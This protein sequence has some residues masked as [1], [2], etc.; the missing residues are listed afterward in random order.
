MPNSILPAGRRLAM[1]FSLLLPAL[2]LGCRDE[3]QGPVEEALTVSA[4]ALTAGGARILGFED[5][6][7]WT[8]TA[9]TKG[10]SSQRI[11]GLYSLSLSN[12]GYVEVRS[13]SLA[14]LGGVADTITIDLTLPTAQP[15]PYWLGTV[16]LK[17]DLPSQGIFAVSLGQREL[18]GQPLGAFR[19]F[20]F[21]LPT[22]VRDKLRATY[23]DLTF[24]VIL[25][26]PAGSGAYLL[27]RLNVGV[28]I[29]GSPGSD[30]NAQSCGPG[31]RCLLQVRSP[32]GLP[33]AL[34]RFVGED[35]ITLADRTV[36][37]DA[38]SK[39]APIATSV[40]AVELGVEAKTG[41][42]Y[43]IGAV[44]LRNNARVDGT[45]RALGQ[46][47]VGSGAT[48]TGTTV[49]T[50]D[51]KPLAVR[52]WVVTI[53]ATFSSGRTVDAD[54][55]AALG[56]PGAYGDVLV[57]SR[58]TLTL[59]S[60][61]YFLKSLAIQSGATVRVDQSGGPLI[62]YVLDS[63][64]YRGSVV[65][66]T[67]AS[68]NLMVGYLGTAP[69]LIEARFGGTF[70]APYATLTLGSTIP[71]QY[72]GAFFAKVLATGPAA[73]VRL[74]PS[75]LDDV[76]DGTLRDCTQSLQLDQSLPEPLRM[77]QAQ[78]DLLRFCLAPG[79]DE[80]ELRMMAIANADRRALALQYVAKAIDAPTH[81]AVTR[82]ITRKVHRM[83]R[84]PALLSKYCDGDDDGDRVPNGDDQCPATPPLTPTTAVGCTDSARPQ[85]APRAVIDLLL[86]RK[87][88]LYN[89]KCDGAAPP[90]VPVPT[91]CGMGIPVPSTVYSLM[92]FHQ[93]TP[94]PEMVPQGCDM[95]YEVQVFSPALRKSYTMAFRLGET[96]SFIPN[97][98]PYKGFVT[99]TTT[100]AEPDDRGR[101]AREV[102]IA[103]LG[104]TPGI[105][106]EEART[107]VV[108]ARAT[109]G[110]GAQSSWSGPV[111]VKCN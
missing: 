49:T 6:A 33:T 98:P 47:T 21:T 79:I 71:A 48:I 55:T 31:G 20:S 78:L 41:D 51:L 62:L 103:A 76:S 4:S 42:I 68:V 91:A 93:L 60:G 53:P 16:G 77:K 9:G 94:L 1:T 30:L 104:G 50:P 39:L 81:L 85:T 106:P 86:G 13:A 38:A 89:P 110:N 54:Q 74:L 12:I 14:T 65:S 101:F 92:T 97:P 28:P 80:C 2:S 95:W 36:V 22:A 25:N 72:S 61:T 90:A 10:R 52:R 109:N 84:E 5:P 44:T 87:G 100:N 107:I 8:A 56:P 18:T 32:K 27:D 7:Q 69:V 75:L 82:D 23:S 59:S 43:S 57:N 64:A 70:V 96:G 83:Q 19:R 63:F 99:F 108:Q 24:T 3:A 29:P 34:A 11:E 102:A 67:G 46:V 66:T 17:V 35:G 40:G 88:I 58:G 73:H 111:A 26:V 105:D 45:V 37:D 15:N